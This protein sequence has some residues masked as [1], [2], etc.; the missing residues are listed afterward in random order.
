MQYSVFVHGT[1]LEIETQANVRGFRKVGWGT[2]ITLYPPV[3]KIVDGLHLE[4]ED[5]PGTWVHLPLVTTLDTFGRF[6]PHL[7]S[8]TLLFETL[9][10]AVGPIHLYDGPD[11]IATMDGAW[12]GEYLRTRQARDVEPKAYTPVGYGGTMENTVVLPKP[13]K[14]F[15]AIGLSFYVHWRYYDFSQ[16]D[17]RADPRPPSILTFAG[18]GAQFLVADKVN[19]LIAAVRQLGAIFR[20]GP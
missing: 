3:T 10:C 7:L 14:V 4:K 17:M 6:S 9:R 11:L 12:P 8:V 13:H 1:G 20:P 2:E 15:S 18:A 5:G 16:E 19:P